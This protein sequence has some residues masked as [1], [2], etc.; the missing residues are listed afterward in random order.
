MFR[1][2]WRVDRRTG[3][4]RPF[5]PRLGGCLLWFLI[6]LAIVLVLALF[7][8]GFRKGTRTSPPLRPV[9]VSQGQLSG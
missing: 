6:L 1:M 8:G 7:F 5:R 9:P 4:E 2:A 3:R